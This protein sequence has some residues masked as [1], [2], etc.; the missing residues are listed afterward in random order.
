MGTHVKKLLRGLGIALIGLMGLA[1]LALAAATHT[2]AEL[3]RVIRQGV[4][5]DGTSTMIMPSSMFHWLTD[6][7]LGRVIGYVRSQPV[8]DGPE[9][10]V[11]LRPVARLFVL[12][13]VFRPQVSM[14][15][16]LPPRAEPDRADPVSWGRYLAL[17]ACT[18]CHGNDLTGAED[19]SSPDLAQVLAYDQ[20]AFDHFMSTGEALG[21]RNL[22]LMSEVARSRFSFFTDDEVDALY[23]FLRAR[24]QGDVETWPGP[25]APTPP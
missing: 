23:S 4:R 11:R 24:A 8:T 22:E 17:T 19:G 13:G 14:I 12:S 3:E 2:D 7:D 21:G 16:E 15:E 20:D 6:E 10:D 18:E 9:T 5:K 1:V 25:R